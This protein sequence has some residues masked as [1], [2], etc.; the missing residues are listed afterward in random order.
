MKRWMEEYMEEMDAWWCD[1]SPWWLHSLI[2]EVSL[3]VGEV[4]NTLCGFQTLDKSVRRRRSSA[5]D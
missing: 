5:E 2:S 1:S 4:I 3:Q